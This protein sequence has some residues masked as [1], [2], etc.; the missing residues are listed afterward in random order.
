MPQRAMNP[1]R[2]GSATAERADKIITA[3]KGGLQGG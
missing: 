2:A 1:E 3:G